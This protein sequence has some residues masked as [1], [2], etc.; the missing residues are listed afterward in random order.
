MDSKQLQ[1][2]ID[3]ELKKAVLEEGFLEKIKGAV[4]R[5]MPNIER[6]RGP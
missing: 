2:I 1:K 3:E 6:A 4:V 5:M